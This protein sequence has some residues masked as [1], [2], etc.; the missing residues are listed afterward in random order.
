MTKNDWLELAV[1]ERKK[2]NL[3]SEV[4]D[5]SRQLGEAMDR[6]DDVSIRLLLSMRQDPILQL[7]ELRRTALLKQ[8]NLTPE[9]RERVEAVISG[10]VSPTAEEESCFEEAGRS[11]RLLERV[12]ELDQRLNRRLAGKNSF[13]AEKK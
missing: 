4:M 11:R 6:S 3:L 5:L 9:E 7:E 13:Y 12:V 2:Y 8:E 1:L 10:S